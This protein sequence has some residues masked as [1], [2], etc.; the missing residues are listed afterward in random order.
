MEPARYGL[1]CWS[2]LRYR[3]HNPDASKRVCWHQAGKLGALLSLLRHFLPPVTLP[4]RPRDKV[5]LFDGVARYSGLRFS[6][7]YVGSSYLFPIVDDQLHRYGACALLLA[8]GPDSFLLCCVG[9]DYLCLL[10]KVLL[11]PELGEEARAG[12][13]RRIRDRAE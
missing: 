12:D 9:T 11:E 8:D 4:V 3:L 10:Q 2:W 6:D 13:G 5:L 1:Q 7:D